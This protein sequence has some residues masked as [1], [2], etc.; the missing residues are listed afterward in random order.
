V[1]NGNGLIGDVRSFGD[2]IVDIVD[3][4]LE[5][6]VRI[7][8]NFAMRRPVGRNRIVDDR[9]AWLHATSLPQARSEETCP[10]VERATE[11]SKSRVLIDA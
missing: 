5:R 8:D 3:R 7:A 2:R 10:S 11:R 6:N 4:C 9:F 1:L